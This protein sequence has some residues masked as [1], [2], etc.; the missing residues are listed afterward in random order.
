MSHRFHH[1]VALL[2]TPNH[3]AWHHIAS[4]IIT[5]HR[6]TSYPTLR[7]T[8]DHSLPLL[9]TPILSLLAT[10]HFSSLLSYHSSLLFSAPL[11]LSSLFFIYLSDMDVQTAISTA[12]KCRPI[13]DPIGQLPDFLHRL[14]KATDKLRSGELEKTASTA[15]ATAA[16]E[17]K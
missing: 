1:L 2:I 11:D 14:K 6:I 16:T 4:L 9:I 15:T 8:S 5:S 13:I 10:P 17:E 3:S 12:K 7:T